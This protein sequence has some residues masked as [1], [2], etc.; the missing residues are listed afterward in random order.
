MMTIVALSCFFY[1]QYFMCCTF[2]EQRDV[3]QQPYFECIL[4]LFD[5]FREKEDLIEKQPGTVVCK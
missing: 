3:E 4:F 2:H 5:V 1:L